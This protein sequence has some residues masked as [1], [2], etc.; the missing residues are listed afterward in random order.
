MDKQCEELISSVIEKI[1][2]LLDYLAKAKEAKR[3]HGHSAQG[4]TPMFQDPN[5]QMDILTENISLLKE[6]L[7]KIEQ[8]AVNLN[9]V[10]NNRSEEEHSPVIC[11]PTSGL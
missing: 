6:T 2:R 4:R 5:T 11:L 7:E 10:T 1:Q 3:A 8:L 9:V